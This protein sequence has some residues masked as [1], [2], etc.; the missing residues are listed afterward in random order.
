MTT[1]PLDMSKDPDR[2]RRDEPVEDPTVVPGLTGPLDMTQ[3]PD[4]YRREVHGSVQHDPAREV[5]HKRFLRGREKRT[6]I[7][8]V[9]PERSY[10]DEVDPWSW[11]LGLAMVVGFLALVAWLFGSVLAP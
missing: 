7:D 8:L 9:G 4:R 2:Y 6:L 1:G 11:A 10:S 3:D 5:P